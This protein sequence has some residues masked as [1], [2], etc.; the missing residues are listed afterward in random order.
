MLFRNRLVVV[1]LWLTTLAAV[2]TF[3]QNRQSQPPMVYS[4]NDLGF[5]VDTS[6]SRGDMIVGTLVVRVNGQWV[7]ASFAR[8]IRPATR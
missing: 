6:Q 2:A 1:V 5:R 4:G 3:A 7:E 8:G